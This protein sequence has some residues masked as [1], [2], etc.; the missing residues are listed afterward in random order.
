VKLGVGAINEFLA[1]ARQSSAGM[2]DSDISVAIRADSSK[3]TPDMEEDTDTNSMR[4]AGSA[5]R[6][7]SAGDVSDKSGAIR[8]E[9]SKAT[10]DME[11]HADSCSEGVA[12]SVPRSESVECLPSLSPSTS[13]ESLTPSTTAEDYRN[14]FP[15]ATPS[16]RDG[17]GK[18]KSRKRTK[19]ASSSAESSPANGREKKPKTNNV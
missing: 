10:P 19:L 17:E 1:D 8:A 14:Q 12:G 4:A 18:V 16:G 5:P 9:S 11:E 13:A 15:L 6:Q 2:G 7:S 3:V